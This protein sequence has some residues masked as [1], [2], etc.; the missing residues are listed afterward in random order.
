M[1]TSEINDNFIIDDKGI[2]REKA[3]YSDAQNQTKETFAFKW[4]KKDSYNSNQMNLS[5][6]NWLMEK[7]FNNNNAMKNQ[8]FAEGNTVLDA[9]C[10]A[11]MSIINMLGDKLKKIHYIGVDI[12]DAIDMA[13]ENFERNGFG[14][15][16]KFIQCDLNHIPI[17]K[18]VDVIFSEGVLHHTDSTQR[19]ILN[20][21]KL[22]TG[23]GYFLFYVYAKKAP[24]REFTDDYIRAY[25]KNKS[26]EETWEEL[27]SLTELG[28]MLGD[29][30]II[31]NIENE[32][33]FL[34]IKSGKVELQRF[35]YWYLFKCFYNSEYDLE[36]MNHI[37][38]DWY[39]P[40]NCHRQTP[41]EVRTW[42]T[43]AGLKIKRM[44]VEDAGITVVAR[45]E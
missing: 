40:Q 25:F 33:P 30:N 2:M 37:N 6:K 11:G 21:S 20:L 16:S 26:N 29:L 24:I 44:N 13:W 12:S 32:I 7:Y 3:I 43:E 4:G 1:K 27:K 38:F 45:K 19:S 31:L 15:N 35:F 8:I 5:L 39:R 41:E 34:G 28:K 9:G 36:E 23:G 14:I 22:L 10:G 42:C 17:T 18:K